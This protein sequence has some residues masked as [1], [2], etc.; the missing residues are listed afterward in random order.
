MQ[1]AST[2]DLQL[3][4][5]AC[6]PDFEL[7]TSVTQKKSVP[8]ANSF[9]IDPISK[10][11]QVQSR[12]CN[13][14]QVTTREDTSIMTRTNNRMLNLG[15]K[16]CIL[17]IQ[18]MHKDSVP[19]YSSMLG[20]KPVMDTPQ[21]MNQLYIFFFQDAKCKSLYCSSG[22]GGCVVMTSFPMLHGTQCGKY[23]VE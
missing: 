13:F 11:T 16:N 10:I 8:P 21:R 1:L 14:Q 18:N 2:R 6:R 12:R 7:R 9:Q 23:K 19:T 17:I 20:E 15:L 4:I 22:N 3:G 5:K